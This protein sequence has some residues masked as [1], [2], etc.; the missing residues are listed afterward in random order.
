MPTRPSLARPR[1]IV[2]TLESRTLLSGSPA[3]DAHSPTS[4]LLG[5]ECP[6]PDRST[7]TCIRSA[8][9]SVR[10][11]LRGSVS[12]P[13]TDFPQRPTRLLAVTAP[14]TEQVTTVR[15]V[16]A[17]L[18][19]ATASPDSGAADASAAEVANAI[20]A[21]VNGS[22]AVPSAPF[23]TLPAQAP[24]VL[25]VSLPRADGPTGGQIALAHN[26]S[27][28]VGGSDMA[29]HVPGDRS[30]Q[31]EAPPK[32]QTDEPAVPEPPDKPNA[33]ADGPPAPQ[34]AGLLSA[35]SAW[36]LSALESAADALSERDPGGGLSLPR[37][38]GACAWAAGAALAW[39]ALRPRR[40]HSEVALTQETT[41]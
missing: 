28:S 26:G 31:G 25:Y 22:S 27:T 23:P 39:L 12:V 11:D 6:G 4:A 19:P 41:P 14:L 21:D 40:N 33:S 2:E 10:G 17:A 16:T 8:D 37:W 20:S 1:L 36:M 18:R 3:P 7:R 29:P 15:A 24:L 9:P 30:S 32:R 34:K 13:Q 35:G 5:A 38:L